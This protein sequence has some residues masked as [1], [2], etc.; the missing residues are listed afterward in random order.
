VRL[1]VLYGETPVPANHGG[2]LDV[3]QRI[4]ALRQAGVEIM[5]VC[6]YS[7]RLG[8]DPDRVAKAASEIASEVH[9]FPA[10]PF[11]DRPR[12]LLRYPGWIAMRVL[13]ADELKRLAE[14][15]RRFAP[16]AILIDGLPCAAAGRQLSAALGQPYLFRSHNRE[17][18]YIKEQ[19]PLNKSWRGR[20]RSLFNLAWLKGFE[21]RVIREATKFYDISRNDLEAWN[22]HGFR[23]G[24]WLPPVMDPGRAARLSAVREWRPRYDVGY[25]GNLVN[26]NNL[27][28]VVWFV[29]QVVPLVRAKMPAAKILIAGSQPGPAIVELCQKAGVDLLQDPPVAETV[30]RDCRVLVNP[31]FQGS[32]VNLKSVEML[33]TPAAL[34]STSI[35]VGGLPETATRHFAIADSPALFAAAILEQLTLQKPPAERILERDGALQIF[36]PRSIETM[37]RQIRAGQAAGA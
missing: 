7:E 25:L 20:V 14:S 34:V 29:E 27:Q 36:A 11:L 22:K 3:L 2:R 13:E 12:L 19:L 35:G 23:H 26:L 37:V 16:D 8:E 21:E 30:L 9:V 18:K 10:R 33:H 5:L 1:V 24:E 28:G 17:Y 31:V 4:L 32:G 15:V 6:W